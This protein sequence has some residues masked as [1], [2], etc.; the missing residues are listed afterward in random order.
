MTC[1]DCNGER[2]VDVHFLLMADG[3]CVPHR[4]VKCSRC[5]GTGEVSGEMVGWIKRGRAL[6]DDR[7]SR[8]LTLRAEAARRGLAPSELS[9]ME[10]GRVEPR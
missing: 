2:E 6:R 10:M 4:R 8:G 1:P 9:A 7:L 3:S 5:Q